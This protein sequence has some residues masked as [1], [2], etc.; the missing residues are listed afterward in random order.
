[1]IDKNVFKKLSYGLYIITSS[2]GKENAGCVV[3]TV[4]QITSNNPVIAISINKDNYTNKIIKESKKLIINILSEKV[5][6]DI[7]TTFGFYSSKD[8]DKFA[9]VNY[10]LVENIPTLK[11]GINGYIEGEVISVTS[12]DTHDI[13]LVKVTSSKVINSDNSLTYKYY[14]ENMKGSSPK[15]APTYIEEEIKDD[16]KPIY[17]CMICGHIYDDNKEDV[18]FASLPDD[19]KCPVCGVGKDKFERIN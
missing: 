4:S 14:Q 3:N 13:F 7:I 6:K 1:M 2:N 10:E 18:P 16:S 5:N 9:N 11:E 17:R 19:W 15:K 8:I 12:V